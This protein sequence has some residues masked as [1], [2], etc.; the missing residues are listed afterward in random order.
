L[1]LFKKT[2]LEKLQKAAADIRFSLHPSPT[3]TYVLDANPNYSNVCTMCC[4]FCSFYKEQGAPG[5]FCKTIEEVMLDIE[6][7]K[8]AGAATVLLQG[9]LSDHTT[10]PYLIELVRK[11]RQRFPDIHP[12]FFSAPEIAHAARI[13]GVPIG[14]ALEELHTAG[15]R[16]IP[17][18]GAEILT[19]SVRSKI[20]PKKL[21]SKEWLETHKQSHKIGFA[22]TATMMFGHIEEAEDIVKHL[23]RLRDVQDQTGGFLSFIP[24]S[25]KPS[26]N[27]L[28]KIVTKTA[29]KEL[30]YRI[31]AFS[32]IFLDNFTN[33]TASWFGEGKA[34]GTTALSYGANDFGGTVF[35][36]SV[37]KSAGHIITSSEE[38][39]RQMICA[40]GFSP[41][42]RN[43]Y[44]HI[45]S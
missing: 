22:T 35:T 2:P 16:T 26:H 24:W 30:Y 37:H 13:S 44:F 6:K 40:A 45:V 43:S 5:A 14:K 31:L 9:G 32:R 29:T 3:V 4:S 21:S 28:G 34:T 10:L 36:E 7:A 23:I 8:N 20:C 12:H 11:T 42:R 38:E 33:I 27:L 19:E 39:I 18:G 15:L 25:Y 41:A 1:L 17:G